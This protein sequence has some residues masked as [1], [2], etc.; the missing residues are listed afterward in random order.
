MSNSLDTLQLCNEKE[1]ISGSNSVFFEVVS[2]YHKVHLQVKS[3]YK[4]R[5]IASSITLWQAITW[6]AINH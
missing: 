5:L 3:I 4:M 6:E 2:L 1:L